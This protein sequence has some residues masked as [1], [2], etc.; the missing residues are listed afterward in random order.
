VATSLVPLLS[1][2][3]LAGVPVPATEALVGL[4]SVLADLDYARHGR[5]LAS[6]GLEAL[7]PEGIRRALDGGDAGLMAEVMA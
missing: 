4:A 7:G 5:T 2:A 6:L 3:R 1:A